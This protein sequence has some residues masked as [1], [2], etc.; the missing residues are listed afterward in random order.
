M[1]LILTKTINRYPDICFVIPHAGAYLP[2]ISDRVTSMSKMLCPEGDDRYLTSHMQNEPDNS[3]NGKSL[4]IASDLEQIENN[5]LKIS[6]NLLP[7]VSE[8][9]MGIFTQVSF[10]HHMEILRK[11]SSLDDRFFYIRECASGSWSKDVDNDGYI[12]YTFSY[13]KALPPGSRKYV[14]FSCH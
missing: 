4:T 3:M 1:N 2:I 13:V 8:F 10:T 14:R 12:E 5:Q 6:S 9:P 11:T 7:M